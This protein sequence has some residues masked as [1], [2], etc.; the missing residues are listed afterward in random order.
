[1][2]VILIA[3]GTG[4][5]GKKLT[6]KLNKK[7]YTV[8]KLT[9]RAKKRGQ[10]YWNPKLKTIEGKHL[11][12][13]HAI[14]N[15][16]GENIGDKRWTESQK[17]KLI[18]SRVQT[19]RF[20]FSCTKNM[21]NLLYYIGASGINCYGNSSDKIKTEK[22]AQGRDFLSNL[23]REWEEASK[24]FSEKVPMSILRI[25]GV[26]DKRKGMLQKMKSPIK[27]GFGSPLGSGKQY[28]PWIHIDDLTELFVHCLEKKLE[29]TYNAVSSCDRNRDFMKMLAIAMRRPFF[30][31][32]I[33]SWIIKLFFGE[34]SVLLL[35]SVNASNEKILNTGFTF[36][37]K[38]LPAAFK[39]IFRKKANN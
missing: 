34:R 9:R 7:G 18:D 25:A 3:G 26:L 5:I 4:L 38:T 12:R 21:P 33:P 27:F 36:Q 19:T 16:T 14:V 24:L 23:V 10:I 6:N 29:G 28:L 20:L 1:M 2:K 37:F 32:R 13:V 30:M 15:L 11:N 31:P 22:S 35:G 39:D 17:E 8:Y